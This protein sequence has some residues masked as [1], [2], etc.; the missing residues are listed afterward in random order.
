MTA[1]LA[2]SSHQ[3]RSQN[4]RTGLEAP[5]GAAAPAPHRGPH[6]GPVHVGPAGSTRG[7]STCWAG[8]CFPQG[9]K[10]HRRREGGLSL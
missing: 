7:I 3:S 10:G 2:A 8:D 6:Q 9:I 5:R 1:L 4:P